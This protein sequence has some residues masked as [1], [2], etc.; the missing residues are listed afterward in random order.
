MKPI[1]VLLVDDHIMVR[2]GVRMMLGSSNQI[3]V[4][5]E[6]GDFDAALELARSQSFDV[7]L[8][9][10]ALPG[11]SGL[12]LIR[13]LKAI[14]PRLAVLMLSMYSEEIYAIRA[15][16]LGAA[17]YL[18]KNSPE[19]VLLDAVHK[20]ANGDKYISPTLANQFA[21][22]L[23]GVGFAA[24]TALSNREL[25]VL[26]LIARG[27]TV[28]NI[29]TT[30]HLSASTIATYRIRILDKLGLKS[31]TELSRYA[32]QHGLGM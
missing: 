16:K 8:L 10:I 4:N 1:S 27:E 32:S 9:D 28:A 20:A 11:G 19:A 18:S 25:E 6:A 12:D 3:C 2:N 14:Q 29:A 13:H 5:A 23:G 24:H 30:L 15:F 22:M 26:K 17:G 21:H 7:A 31:N